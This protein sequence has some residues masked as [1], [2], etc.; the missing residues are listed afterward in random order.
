MNPEP[1]P[2]HHLELAVRVQIH[3]HRRRVDRGLVDWATHAR[4]VFTVSS[5]EIN[6]R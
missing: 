3:D 4:T 5:S 2:D 6:Q 1:R